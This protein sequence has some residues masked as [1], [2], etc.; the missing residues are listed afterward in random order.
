MGM[1]TAR[2]RAAALL[3][4]GAH[5]SRLPG[6]VMAYPTRPDQGIRNVPVSIPDTLQ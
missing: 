3:R 5:R 6:P 4:L 2:E 1:G